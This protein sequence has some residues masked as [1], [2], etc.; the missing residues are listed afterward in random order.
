MHVIMQV[1]RDTSMSYIILASFVYK[2]LTTIVRG[3]QNLQGSQEW[4]HNN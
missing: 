2:H 3:I 1:N 4:G